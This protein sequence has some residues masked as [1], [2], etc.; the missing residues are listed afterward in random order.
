MHAVPRCGRL[1]QM[2]RALCVS[3]RVSVCLSVRPLVTTMSVA[4]T[5]EE[6]ET[7]CGLWTR[8]RPRFGSPRGRGNLGAS[9]RP[10]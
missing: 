7:P 9:P 4:E 2:L 6:I 8:M 5:A 1:L 3:V 10:L